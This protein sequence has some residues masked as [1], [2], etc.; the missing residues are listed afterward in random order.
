MLLFSASVQA[1]QWESV[2]SDRIA[3]TRS[4]AHNNDVEVRSARGCIIV[5]TNRSVQ[6]KVY[7]I[8]GQLVSQET[9]SPGVSQLR[10]DSK[11]VFI[12]KV[13]DLT[14]KVAL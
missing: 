14:C 9:L 6:I 13:A 3:E 4:V 1:K 7:T 5:S 8:L 12:V 2:R 11:G 10:I